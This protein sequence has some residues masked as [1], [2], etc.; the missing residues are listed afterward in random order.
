M[1]RFSTELDSPHTILAYRPNLIAP[2]DHVHSLGLA[3]NQV[4]PSWCG[5]MSTICNRLGPPIRLF[6]HDQETGAGGPPQVFDIAVT[7]HAVPLNPALSVRGPDTRVV[8]GKTSEISVEQARK[9]LTSIDTTHVVGLAT[10]PSW[11]R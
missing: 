10:G 3:L 4:T 8:E 5:P 7:R 11:R 6:R 9:L 2:L 1:K